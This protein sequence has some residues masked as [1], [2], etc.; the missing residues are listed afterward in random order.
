[1]ELG[2]WLLGSLSGVFSPGTE[3]EDWVCENVHLLVE[4]HACS[5]PPYR[6]VRK[7]RLKQASAFGA[8]VQESWSN[9]PTRP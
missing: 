7:Q 2:A 4:D 1:M 5:L 8:Q 9:L 3:H 6:W